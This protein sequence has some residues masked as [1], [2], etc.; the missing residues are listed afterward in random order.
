LLAALRELEHAQTDGRASHR[1]LIRTVIAQIEGLVGSGVAQCDVTSMREFLDRVAAGE[2]A[3]HTVATQQLPSVTEALGRLKTEG[4]DT[5]SERVQ[6]VLDQVAQLWTAAQ[7]VNASQAMTFF[8]GLH[9]FL[10]VV[11]QRRLVVAARRY[12]AI[13]SRLRAM[14]GLIQV[15][16]DTGREERTA[17]CSLLPS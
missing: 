13:E 5:S 7:Q 15:W 2:E 11:T 6:I 9:S 16:V 10:S 3:F 12:D 17:V 1:N 8:M 4:R 14:T